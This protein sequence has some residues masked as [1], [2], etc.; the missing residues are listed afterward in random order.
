MNRR[1]LLVL[2]LLIAGAM[3]LGNAVSAR[4]IVFSDPVLE[5]IIRQSEGFSGRDSGPIF[6]EDLL[7][8]TTVSVVDSEF[9]VSLEGI[10]QLINLI[11]LDFFHNRVTDLSPLQS[12]VTLQEL[13][14]WDN[15]ISD[16]SPLR[17]L[18]HLREV[19]FGDNPVQDISVL[20][21]LTELEEVGFWEC[22]IEDISVLRGL[23][24]LEKVY[25][26]GNLIRD[27]SA[28]EG[29]SQLKLIDL[30]TNLIE[31]ITPLAK[32]SYLGTGTSIDLRLN[33]LSFLPG[34]PNR[35]ALQTLIERGCEIKT[36]P[37][38]QDL[39]TA[40]EELGKEPILF[41][42]P[43][44]EKGI[45][46]AWGYTGKPEGPIYPVDT[47]NIFALEIPS[48]SGLTS[49]EGIQSLVFLEELWFAGNQVQDL[50]PLKTLTNLEFL[51]ASENRV[52]DLRPLEGLKNLTRLWITDNEIRDLSPLRALTL[53]QELY[54]SRNLIVDLSPLEK[55]IHLTRLDLAGNQ[56]QS[57]AP[58]KN[59]SALQRLDCERNAVRDIGSLFC[60]T[61]W[62]SDT[63]IDIRWNGID[64][65]ADSRMIECISLQQNRGVV[66]L[67]EPQN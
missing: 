9:L 6:A 47:I 10:Q 33:H 52:S 57:I 32:N 13:G 17:H 28:F 5:R 20:R 18:V 67:Y 16:L 42:D 61:A 66:I 19:F 39:L 60:Q 46:S 55:L 54:L 14:F 23:P 43:I 35:E 24:R 25:C 4:E 59:L 50:S 40:T 11:E 64:L 15:Q 41:P 30:D 26:P 27:I 36:K 49:L 51:W 65:S 29:L 38:R 45:R 63:Y 8:I 34:T 48:E 31:D 56:I 7:G 22:G 58:L 21:F 44:L 1:I 2:V 37:Q 62:A 53:L 3:A 12:L